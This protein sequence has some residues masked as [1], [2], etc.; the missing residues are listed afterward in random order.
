MRIRRQYIYKKYA[1]CVYLRTSYPLSL[2]FIIFKLNS[3]A[4]IFSLLCLCIFY[5]LKSC[6]WG[7]FIGTGQEL[8]G[9]GVGI[10]ILGG[11]SLFFSP[12]R[13]DLF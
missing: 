13:Q 2:T 9:S 1:K 7:V 8:D 5:Y 12:R 3:I 11:A 4:F 6:D 10:R